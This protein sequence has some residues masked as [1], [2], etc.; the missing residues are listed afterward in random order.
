MATQA[1]IELF[2]KTVNE[3]YEWV[4]E[5]DSETG[6]DDRHYAFAAL[7]GTLHAIRDEI[8]ADQSGHVSAQLPTLL[9]GVYFE[10]WD[11]SR[12]PADDRT[13][14]GFLDHV[15]PAFTAYGSEYDLAE[16]VHDTLAVIERKL[17]DVMAKVKHTLP[18]HIRHLWS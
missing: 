13:V 3:S 5:V 6:L 14:D 16:I 17:P 9:R 10:G 15:R 2:E 11:P 18:K 8:T 7:R 4:N 1:R 12:I